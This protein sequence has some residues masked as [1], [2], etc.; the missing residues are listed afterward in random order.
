V[1]IKIVGINYFPEVTGIAPYTTGMAEGLAAYAHDVSLV[2]GL[3]H[4]PEWRIYAAYR[5]RR[6]YRETVNGVTIDR[7]RHYVPRN[8][9]LRNRIRME[10]SSPEQ[11]WPQSSTGRR[12]SSPSVRR[13]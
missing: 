11:R 7:L 12:L 5:S 9:G 10:A 13:S 4:Y 6:S 2:T 8:P 1:K 3:P